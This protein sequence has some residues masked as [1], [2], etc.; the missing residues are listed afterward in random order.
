[1]PGERM[2]EADRI[3]LERYLTEGLNVQGIS[4][5]DGVPGVM[6]LTELTELK[7]RKEKIL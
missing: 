5:K 4:P 3:R 7:I 2:E 1:M 6:V